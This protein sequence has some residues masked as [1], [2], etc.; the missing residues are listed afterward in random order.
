MERIHQT[1]AH[2]HRP[3]KQERKYCQKVFDH[4]IRCCGRC[5][6]RPP[7]LLF[8]FF[9][10]LFFL[11]LLLI[12]FLH[13]ILFPAYKRVEKALACNSFTEIGWQT[14]HGKRI[15]TNKKW[16][17]RFWQNTHTHTKASICHRQTNRQTDI[18]TTITYERV[19]EWGNLKGNKSVDKLGQFKAAVK[20]IL[21]V[22]GHF[23][24]GDGKEDGV[25]ERGQD[26]LK[27]RNRKER[28]A[29]KEDVWVDQ[30][31]QNRWKTKSDEIRKG[32]RSRIRFQGSKDKFFIS[33]NACLSVDWAQGR[34]GMFEML[35]GHVSSWPDIRMPKR[36]LKGSLGV[37]KI[38]SK[39]KQSYWFSKL[40]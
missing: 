23:E 24:C 16:L 11:L 34:L 38:E 14:E 21:E 26:I 9:L 6:P 17:S 12:L 4:K 10:L 31:R 19:S 39:F 7:L 27:R 30:G 25:R 5:R 29:K 32:N 8:F 36:V 2:A 40:I 37:S 1:V 28:T 33:R 15:S 20:L 22:I 3:G 13:L 18:T 35:S